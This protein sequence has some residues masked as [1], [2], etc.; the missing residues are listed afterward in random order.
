MLGDKGM[1]KELCACASTHT[2]VWQCAVHES[3]WA[4]GLD[5]SSIQSM[6]MAREVGLWQRRQRSEQPISWVG[7]KM[8]VP[9]YAHANCSPKAFMYPNTVNMHTPRNHTC[10]SAFR[11]GTCAESGS[12]CLCSAATFQE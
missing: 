8:G 7:V 3:F 9:V 1:V 10:P 2:G 5:K 6:S 11:C 12:L 4:N